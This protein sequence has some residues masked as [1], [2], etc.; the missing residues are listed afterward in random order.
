MK[1]EAYV[2]VRVD[3]DSSEDPH[4]IISRADCKFNCKEIKDAEIVEVCIDA[5][6]PYI[7]S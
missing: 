7:A 5:I 6:Y 1:Q 3:F 2:L 4:D